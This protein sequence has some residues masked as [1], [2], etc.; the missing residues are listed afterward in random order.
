[1]N[2]LP[3]EYF[4][5]IATVALAAIAANQHPGTSCRIEIAHCS[6]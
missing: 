1:M 6:R 3:V 4:A 2:R 5:M